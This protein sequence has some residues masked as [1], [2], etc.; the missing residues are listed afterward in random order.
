[1][2]ETE[3][4]WFLSNQTL[5]LQCR[6]GYVTQSLELN[7]GIKIPLDIFNNCTNS[8]SMWLLCQFL[9][10]VNWSTLIVWSLHTGKEAQ[11]MSPIYIQIISKIA[12]YMT[13]KISGYR[14]SF[15]T[16]KCRNNQ[17]KSVIGTTKKLLIDM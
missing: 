9:S 16:K 2:L 14:T 13:W 3:V 4:A 10:L 5:F 17:Y 7:L 12:N 6:Y 11:K 1:M 15:F 8:M